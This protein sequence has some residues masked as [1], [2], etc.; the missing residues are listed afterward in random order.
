MGSSRPVT[1]CAAVS[2]DNCPGCSVKGKTIA[3]KVLAVVFFYL[4]YCEPPFVGGEAILYTEMEIASL[5]WVSYGLRPAQPSACLAM[6]ND[7]TLGIKG[8]LYA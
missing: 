4:R 8:D 3:K 1:G 5:G 7:V 6:T 2:T